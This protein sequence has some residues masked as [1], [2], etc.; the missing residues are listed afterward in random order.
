MIKL[1]VEH[2]LGVYRARLEMQEKGL[3]NPPE[4]IKVWVRAIVERLSKLPLDE[5]IT[6]DGSKLIDSNG[7]AVA[8]MP[9]ENL[10]AR[11][12]LDVYQTRL[13]M[14]EEG[15]TNPPE[16]IRMLVR[17]IVEKLSRMPLDE[18]IILENGK[19]IDSS[20]NII[21]EFPN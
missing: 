6:Q 1:K 12:Y 2:Y 20:G 5:I 11:H 16:E 19:M 17:T 4:Q 3:I 8:E 21:V 15:I 18:K 9:T 10:N 14:Q 7:N 13:E